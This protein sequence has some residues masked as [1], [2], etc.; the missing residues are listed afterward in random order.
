M[1]G[2]PTIRF[3]QNPTVEDLDIVEFVSQEQ[4][5][6]LKQEDFRQ[7]HIKGIMI[8]R[9]QIKKIEA[10]LAETK[11]QRIVNEKDLE[12]IREQRARLF[13]KDSKKH[14]IEIAKLD[15]E[16]D[17][18]RNFVA[19]TPA[20]INVLERQLA[21]AKQKFAAE[22]KDELASQQKAVTSEALKLSKQLVAQLKAAVDTNQKLHTAYGQY[23]K[24]H[25]L[26]KSDSLGNHFAEPSIQMLGFL[27]GHLRGELEEGKHVRMQMHPPV[28]FI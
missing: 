27:Y 11:N 28:E 14:K 24:L 8:M 1:K 4:R 7:L 2:F 9:K 25:D 3:I 10:K 23:K 15:T 26:T 16:I 12:R 6:A 21:E 19:N 13:V 5:E 17:K 20:V 18:L 22:A